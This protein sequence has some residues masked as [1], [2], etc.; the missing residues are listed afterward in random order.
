M[1]VKD[2]ARGTADL[3]RLVASDPDLVRS[4]MRAAPQEVLEGEK[5]ET[6]GAAKAAG[7]RNGS[8]IG[9]GTMAGRW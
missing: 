5:T 9:P 4:L 2:A 3:E 8:V 1:T 6:V 7:R